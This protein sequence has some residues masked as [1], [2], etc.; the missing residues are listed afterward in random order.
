MEAGLLAENERLSAE[1]ARA[2]A[3]IRQAKDIHP[4]L[5]LLSLID[6]LERIVSAG[7]SR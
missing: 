7:G 5:S 2:N 6:C 3:I 1:L 4:S